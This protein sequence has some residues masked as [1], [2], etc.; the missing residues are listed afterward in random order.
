[1]SSLQLNLP[2]SAVL[3]P[4]K[5]GKTA[6]AAIRKADMDAYFAALGACVAEVQ[7]VFRLSLEQFAYELGMDERQLSRQMT[8]KERPQLEKVFAVDR[9]RAVLLIALAKLA[10]DVDVVTEIRIRR[11]A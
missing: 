2:P 8:G 7:G 10:A 1:M 3:L 11:S 9:F 5:G 6:K 4:E